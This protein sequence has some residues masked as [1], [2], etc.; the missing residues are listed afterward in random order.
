MQTILPNI[1]LSENTR[2]SV[3]GESQQEMLEEKR[4]S[5]SQPYRRAPRLPESE[6]SGFIK[7]RFL[8][9]RKGGAQSTNFCL[10]AGNYRTAAVEKVDFTQFSINNFLSKVQ[11]VLLSWLFIKTRSIID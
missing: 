3:L 10:P 9:A 4:K 6:Y 1:C 11:I 7:R 2:S 8:R 5:S